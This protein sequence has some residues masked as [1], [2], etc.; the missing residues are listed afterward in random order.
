MPEQFSILQLA[1]VAVLVA[2]S[3]VWSVGLVRLLRRGRFE[4]AVGRSGPPLPVLPQQR[5]YGPRLESVEL[6]PAEEDAFAGLV[7]QFSGDS[8]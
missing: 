3:V 4:A 7:R 8:H 1:G 2:A 5:R 6:T